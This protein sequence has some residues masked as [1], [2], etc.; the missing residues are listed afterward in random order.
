MADVNFLAD[1]FPWILEGSHGIYSLYPKY[2][3][4]ISG[5]TYACAFYKTKQRIENLK[6]EDLYLPEEKNFRG[7]LS[8]AT[9]PQFFEKKSGKVVRLYIDANNFF[10]WSLIQVLPYGEYGSVEKSM[11]VT[12]ATEDDIENGYFV[13]V[14]SIFTDF[15]KINTVVSILSNF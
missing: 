8:W 10:A 3:L 5:Y 7:E 9:G 4:W 14:G 13:E 6:G 2:V 1:V 11:E 12:L 15:Q